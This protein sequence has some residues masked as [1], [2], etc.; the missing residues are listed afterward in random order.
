[1]EA[2]GNLEWND[3]DLRI[4]LPR[5]NSELVREGNVLRHCVGGYGQQHCSGKLIFFVRKFRRPDRSYYT[6]NIDMTSGQPKQIQLHG[7]GNERHG[8]NK[9]YR[10]KI[11]QKVLDFVERW[12]KEVLMPWWLQQ[13]HTDKKE[14]TA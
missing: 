11:P 5:S 2:Y 4:L 8:K 10:H 14:R 1:M 9:E 6:L 3:G 12:K 7:Y 13:I